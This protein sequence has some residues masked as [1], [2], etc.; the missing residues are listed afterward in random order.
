MAR[1]T[2][3]RNGVPNWVDVA[4]T[5]VP[6]AAS[7]YGELFGWH[8]EDQGEEAGHYTMCSIDGASVAGI[9]PKFNPDGMPIWSTYIAVDD[10]AATL[11]KV[12]PA[13]GSVKMEP[14]EIPGSGTMAAVV[15]PT[16]A[17]VA[18]W[19]ASQH[20]GCEVVNED[21]T[22]VW[23]E[24]TTRDADAAAAF[25]EAVLG[26]SFQ[27]MEG[28][29]FGGYRTMQVGDRT[30]GGVMAMEGEQ[31]GDMPSHWMV[32][33]G[34][35]D[36]DATASKATDLGGSVSVPPFDTPVG[37]IAVLNDPTGN[38]FSVIDFSDDADP[39]EGGIA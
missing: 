27:T 24:L 23:N 5:D 25:Y 2:K 4:T 3:Y 21:N 7:F 14:M 26:C 34:T 11:A 13:G 28:E 39:V 29:E 36:A 6:G 15:D 31:W 8:T 18:F 32:Y 19:Q 9:G 17:I 38:A 22:L 20:I 33:F 10:L 37:R 30:V 1:I 12:E 35:G 16:G